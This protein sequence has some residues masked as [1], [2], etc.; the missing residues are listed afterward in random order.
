METSTLKFGLEIA[1]ALIG[2]IC[3]AFFAYV[4]ILSRKAK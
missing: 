3:I 2:V 4:M 1:A